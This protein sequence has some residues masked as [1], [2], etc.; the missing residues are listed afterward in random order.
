MVA[1]HAAARATAPDSCLKRLRSWHELAAASDPQRLR[2]LDGPRRRRHSARRRARRGRQDRRHRQQSRGH[3]RGAGRRVRD[4]RDARLRR[5][6]SA[7]VADAR[8]RRPSLVH[9]RPL[10]RRDARP[11]RRLLPPGGRAHRRLR[12]L[13]RGV[14]RRR[15]DTARLVAH[16]Q[17]ARPLGRGDPGPEGRRHPRRLRARHADRRRVVVVQLTRAPGGHPPHPRHVL[18]VRRRSAHAR[19]GGAPARQ[20]DARRREARLGA[21]ARARDPDQ[22]ARRHAAAHAALHAG[23]GHAR[24]RA[25]GSGRLLH[26]HDRPHRRGARLHRRDRREGVDRA[27]RRD[28]DGPWAAADREDARPRRS[29]LVERRR[30]LERSRRDV[31][32]DADGARLRPHPRVHRHAGHRVRAEAPAH[33][34]ARLR[35]HRRR[36]GDRARGQ[37]R[38]AHARQA[39]RHR[40]APDQ[41]DQHRAGDRPEGDD[42]CVLRHVERRHGVRR[43]QC[44]Q[45]QRAAR[46]RRHEV[47]RAE[48]RGVAQFHSRAGWVC[49]PSGQRRRPRAHSH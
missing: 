10:F 30:R 35:D 48:A 43:R 47:D 11:G 45:A 18:L 6:A 28:A 5:H 8:P 46:R 25:D 12:R 20:R 26:P 38:L 23:E 24:P 4:D 32:A 41:R 3:G 27:V 1:V 33:G 7:H 2:R 13:A 37:G 39:G 22:R 16:Q 36:P 31:H 17:H 44:G 40:P 14:E 34:R 29:L 19:D 15:H 9:A 21:R 49:C 42:R